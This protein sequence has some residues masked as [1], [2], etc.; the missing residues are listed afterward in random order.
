ERPLGAREPMA[1]GS[2]E[3]HAALRRMEASSVATDA[4]RGIRGVPPRGRGMTFSR[5]TAFFFLATVFS[6]S[7]E[8]LHW[9]VAGSVSL[10]DLLAILFVFTF[11]AGRWLEHGTGLTRTALVALA[12]ALAFALV[13][14]LGFFNLDTRQALE[15]F[16]KGLVKFG[17]H[18]AF[19]AGG[20]AYVVRRGIHFYW[21]TLGWLTGGLLANALYGVAQL[22][23]ANRG[24]DLD[25]SVLSPITGGAS[26]INIYGAVEGQDVYRPNALTGDPNHLAIML[27]VPLLVLPPPHR[28]A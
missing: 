2:T 12:F 15:Q 14:L 28:R 9:E 7:F 17:I 3:R 23:V 6:V 22:V 1:R 16:V 19:L 8:K 25:R 13:Y 11:V 10:A 24:G 20:I 27:I 5:V 26:S 4:C 21:Q 18:F